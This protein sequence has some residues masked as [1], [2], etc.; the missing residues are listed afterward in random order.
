VK[1]LWGMLPRRP[2]RGR[3]V[4]AVIDSG[5]WAGALVLCS[6]LRLGSDGIAWWRLF[7]LVPLVVVAQLLAGTLFGLY[8]GRWVFGSVEEVTAVGKSFLLAGAGL[9]AVDAAMTSNRP[10]PISVV[11]AGGTMAVLIMVGVRFGWRMDYD[12]QLR[13]RLQGRPCERVIVFGAGNGGRAAL[14]AMFADPESSYAA[15]ALL[16]D[17]PHMRGVTTHGVKVVGDRHDMGQAAAD[18]N[19]T[20]VVIAVPSASSSLV[21]ELSEI[22]T[23]AGLTVRVLPSVRELLDGGVRVI[24]IREPTERDLM[25]RHSIEIDLDQAAVFLRDKR[26]LVTGAGGSIGSELC[27]QIARFDPAE[28]LMVDRDESALHAVQLS[29]TGRAMLDTPDLALLDIRDRDRVRQL[30]LERRPEVVFHAA[31]LKH[32]PLLEAH[33][34]EGFKTNV[35]GS[36]AVLEAAKDAGVEC[37]VNI[38]T[39]KAADPCSILGYS[40]RVAEGLTAGVDDDAPGRFLSVRFGNV[41]GSRGSFL[42]AFQKQLELGGPL[43]VTHPDVT[44]FFMTVE[45]AVQLVLQ[46]GAIGHGGQVLVLDMGEPVNIAEVAEQLAQSVKPPCPIEFV[47]LRRGEKLHEELFGVAEAPSRTAH[48]L[49]RSVAVPSLDGDCV[50][51]FPTTITPER[52]ARALVDL[53]NQMRLELDETDPDQIPHDWRAVAGGS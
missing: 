2:H 30:F 48:P 34:V 29:I 46:A 44:R 26:V 3:R 42:T 47:G 14:K 43:T 36:L 38:S 52:A 51:H 35:W 27:R 10:L 24:D 18:F 23:K 50:R 49:I 22:A 13:R 31:A 5:A 16:D 9:L 11:L 37:F 53:C 45:E 17:D 28:L 33:P 40:K 1:G 21:L 15:V 7:P 32:L 8:R 41:L 4:Q 19:A 39:D 25:G 6:G 12:R 20:G